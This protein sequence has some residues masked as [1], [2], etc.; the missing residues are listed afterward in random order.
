MSIARRTNI[1]VLCIIFIF[2]LTACGGPSASQIQT[3]P[4]PSQT[5]ASGQGQ[6][7]LA[8]VA[9]R[10]N[11]AKTL[12][13]VFDTTINGQVL[14]GTIDTE[15][16]N[17]SPD[18]NRSVVLQS[19]VS[20]F[21]TG[22]VAITNGKY[23]W[24]YDPTKKVVYSGQ[25]SQTG[26]ATV[27]S[28]FRT[29][30]SSSLSILKLVQS[31]F[32]RSDAT[33]VSSSATINGHAAYDLHVIP[34]DSTGAASSSTPGPD[35]FNYE[36]EVYVDK[37]TE[38]PLQ[39][40]LTISGFGQVLLNMN[41]V[42]LNSPISNSL[43]TFVPPAGVKILPLQQASAAS[44]TGSITLAQAEQQAGYHLLSISSSQTGY[45]LQGVDALG[46]PG[47]QI[48]TLNYT[49]GTLNFTISEGKPL[50]NLPVSGQQVS[51]RGTVATLSTSNGASTLAWTEHGLGMQIMGELSTGQV[52]AI[53]NL[54]S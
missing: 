29:G 12:H 31:I 38:L 20:R 54:L 50:A 19:T 47:N 13:A 32:T 18:K 27:G 24:Q 44:D 35:N 37:G 8:K 3:G 9:Q 41:N 39:V 26:T 52:E 45:V 6:Q 21:P 23:V 46:S 30:D 48:Y 10:L 15:V 5:L 28:T 43:F 4:T 40:S 25:V 11:A 16:W 53:A 51:I 14:A 33:L 42:V 17:V 7:L 22:S 49:E 36:G 1:L 2:L 34:Q